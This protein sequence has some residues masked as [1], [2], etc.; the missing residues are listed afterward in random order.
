MS[1]IN[2]IIT[3][4]ED[5]KKLLNDWLNDQLK[6]HSKPLSRA[7]LADFLDVSTVTITEWVKKGLPHHRLYG[8][9]YFLKEEVMAAMPTIIRNNQSNPS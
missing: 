4:Q 1:E 5:L 8:R 3:K 7:E 9:V 6:S 2:F